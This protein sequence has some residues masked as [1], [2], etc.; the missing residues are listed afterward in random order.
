MKYWIAFIVALF[1]L[2]SCAQRLMRSHLVG[3]STSKCILV[4][5][6]M[7]SYGDPKAYEFRKYNAFNLKPGDYLIGYFIDTGFVHT[8]IMHVSHEKRVQDQFILI[9]PVP[10]HKV[11][12][13]PADNGDSTSFFFDLDYLDP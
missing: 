2:D 11:R 5:R 6:D 13:A 1:C 10:L 7:D 9:R 12:F 3:D 8:E 4:I